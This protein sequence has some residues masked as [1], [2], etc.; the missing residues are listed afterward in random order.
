MPFN[1][2]QSG[3]IGSVPAGDELWGLVL[4]EH[5]PNLNRQ[6]IATPELKFPTTQLDTATGKDYFVDGPT[7]SYQKLN[8][9]GTV[10]TSYIYLT[11]RRGGRFI[12]A[13]DVSTPTAPKFLWRID[14][15]T[16]GFNDLGQ[17]WSRPRLTLLQ[18]ST[19][20]TT[21]VLVFGGGYDP[22]E[23]S[24]PPAADSMGRAIYIV[25]AVDGSL[26]WS[27]S[28]TCTTSSTCL[29]VPNMTYAI[30]SDVTFI[31]R[32]L[33]GYTDK[34]YV[35]DVG[36]NLWR[37]DVSAAATTS[38]TVTRVAALGCDSGPCAAGTTPRKFFFPPAVLTVLPGGQAGAYDAIGIVSGDREHPLQST[39]T[40][41]AAMTPDKFFLV[42]DTTTTLSPSTFA[43]TDVHLS[44]GLFD[45]TSTV[46]DGTLNGFYISMRSAEKGVNAPLAVNG[47]IFFS[48]NQPSAPTATCAANLGIA[49]AYAVSPFTSESANNVLSGGGLPPSPVAG[50]V[51][52]SG[53]DGQGH[54]T[55]HE[56]RFCIG[57][58][59]SSLPGTPPSTPGTCA[60]NAALQNCTPSITIPSNLKR[61][62]WYKKQGS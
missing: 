3:A 46:W 10:N 33:D 6:R 52:I 15:N 40:G 38:W 49:R 59:V 18:S 43:T 55:T 32:D 48:T 57:C 60:G 61:T 22:A 19:Y 51:S 41:S 12:Y 28:P 20:K 24:E 31:D 21:P 37:I 30:P 7:G 4:P 42:K 14:A 56:E 13:L 62:Y 8:A 35:G 50:L 26:I 45:A 53:T 1:G 5:Y 44:G 9:D 54:T 11:M 39:A 25:N 34:I 27:A 23:D 29:N 16:V 2:N 47:L 58:G 36:G 17:T